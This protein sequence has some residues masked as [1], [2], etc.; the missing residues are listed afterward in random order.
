MKFMSFKDLSSKTGTPMKP[1]GTEA[2]KP[3]SE[4]KAPTP[5]AAKP[6]DK[7]RTP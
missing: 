7:P 1:T 4:T 5:A 6:M 2:P 3:N